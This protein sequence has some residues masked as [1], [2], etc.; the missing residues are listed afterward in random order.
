MVQASLLPP[1][2]QAAGITRESLAEHIQSEIARTCGPQLP[3]YR[4]AEIV[5]GFFERFGARDAMAICD[6]AF[7]A[8]AGM[9]RGAPVTLL[10]FQAA[11]DG[12]FSC[13]LLEEARAVRP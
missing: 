2:A 12:Y 6:R 10:R 7:G 4:V 13:P 8:H 11:H 9:W 3:C 1:S 5:N